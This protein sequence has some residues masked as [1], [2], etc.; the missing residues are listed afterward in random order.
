MPYKSLEITP[1]QYN[2]GFTEQTSQ[3]YRG[4]S[5]VDTTANDVKLYDNALIKQDI[6][7][8]FQVRKGE[9]VMMPNFG[10]IIWDLLYEPLT[11]TVKSQI[12]K[13]I[14]RICTSDPRVTCS[15]IDIVQ[16]DYGFLLEVTLTYINSNQSET[17]KFNFDKEVG[18]NNN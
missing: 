10:T 17:I 4:F 11:D 15:Q 9:R 13:D 5:T 12:Q 16:S 1:T 18:L 2:A 7:N 14:T 3:F 8:Q 6:F